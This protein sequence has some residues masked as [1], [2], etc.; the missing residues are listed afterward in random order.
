VNYRQEPLALRLLNPSS[1][2]PSLRGSQASLA[3]AAGQ[4][5]GAGDPAFAF[6]SDI[7]RAMEEL[8]RQPTTYPPL[9]ADLQPG[10][11]WTPMLRAYKR[12]RVQVRMLVGATEEPHSIHINGMR[13]LLNPDDPNSGWRSSQQQGISEHFEFEAPIVPPEADLGDS[14]DYLYAG[15]ASAEGFWNGAWGLVRTYE[16][17]QGT[18]RP[19]PNNPVA[20]ARKTI[21]LGGGQSASVGISGNAGNL[22]DFN[23]VCPKTAPVRSYAVS[24]VAASQAIGAT[25]IT[26]NSRQGA[27][28]GQRGPITDPT[29]ALYVLDSDLD[30]KTGRILAGRPIE[31][32]VLR[33]AAGD[34]IEVKLTNRLPANWA[35]Q[36]VA[37]AN[38]GFYMLPMMVEGF[39]ANQLRPSMQV[40]LNPELLAWDVTRSDGLNV[41]LNATTRNKVRT[42][43]QTVGPGEN[44]T[45]R[46]YA[47]L[48]TMGA[49]NTLVA[50][51]VEFGAINLM[52]A[53]P[54]R[55]GGKGLVA[56][57]VVLPQGSTWTTDAT[58]RTAAT[59]TVPGGRTFRDFVLMFQ[60]DLNLRA[61]NQPVCPVGA[62][63]E[64]AEPGEAPPS[65]TT[66][67]CK[68]LDEAQDAGNVA[69]NYR[70][71]PLWFRLGHAPGENP[72]L[73]RERTDY[74]RALSN[75]LVGGDPQTPVFTA[76]KGQEVR[77]RLLQASGHE[78]SGVFALHGHNW[79]RMPYA[80]ANGT[81]SARIN[82]GAASPA[83][84]VRD[85][86]G[87]TQHYDVVIEQAGGPNGI[88]GDYLFR[89]LMPDAF[90]G[91]Q[92]GILR[93]R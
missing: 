28:A 74:H 86:L 5:G 14:T 75:E 45:Y 76:A 22:P 21:N 64:E 70:T 31:P 37:P 63:E 59:V 41:G 61:G 30:L 84:G 55:Q 71:E 19:L 24:A 72:G 11:P 57:M 49:N 81:P 62:G 92:W 82:G 44:V 10:D 53:E 23:G 54:L 79:A 29:G 9:T 3:P 48:V 93:V 4:G 42:I 89:N 16:V 34:C 91:G 8:N 65:I 33:A 20:A 46:W 39:N 40:G 18:L 90:D 87:P 43:R 32:L 68:G 67:G 77:F 83:T 47:G 80:A 27:F 35:E 60:D 15:S 25:G 52:P 38:Q 78:R 56:A 26:Y 7:T 17:L 12:D 50:T 85:A 1:R 73:T 6:R 66:T 2:Q 58:T 36:V 51:P 69:L 13:W 88:A